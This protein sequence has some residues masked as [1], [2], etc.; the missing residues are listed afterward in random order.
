MIY[1]TDTNRVLVWDNAAWVMI[2]DTD[3]PPALELVKT[4]TIGSA[5]AS[6][7]VTDAF[8]ATYDNYKITI[9]GGSASTALDIRCTLGS[10]TSGYYGFIVYGAY[11]SNTVLGFAQNN[12]A[13]WGYVG[14]GNTILHGSFELSNPFASTRTTVVASNAL[15]LT[16]GSA[17]QFGGYLNDSNS[18][19][20]FT[21][22]ASTGTMTGGTIRVYGYRN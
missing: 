13:F 1:E 17:N 22:T 19:T 8:S 12:T 16:T 18:Y 11:N 9:N 6:V 20:S 10:A 15:S 3:T 21:L 14:T 7:T 5:V 2:A 4:Q